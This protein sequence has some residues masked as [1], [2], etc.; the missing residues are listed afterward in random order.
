MAIMDIYE[1]I[2]S[3][4]IPKNEILGELLEMEQYRKS[5]IKTLFTLIEN[6]RWEDNKENFFS[7]F[8][9]ANDK[10]NRKSMMNSGLQRSM[11]SYEERVI[12]HILNIECKF[13]SYYNTEQT[14]VYT[15]EIL[16]TLVPDRWHELIEDLQNDQ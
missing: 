2:E 12:K 9:W 5:A 8:L 15:K 6:K 1:K 16:E 10:N 13:K 4:F 7:L 11:P 3:W 14:S